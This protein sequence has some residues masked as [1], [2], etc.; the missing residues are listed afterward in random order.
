MGENRRGQR[1]AHA[2][3]V[4]FGTRF[5]DAV[6]YEIEALDAGDFALFLAADRFPCEAR[7]GAFESIGARLAVLCRERFSN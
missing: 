1:S 7:P 5:W 3:S 6:E 2:V 4:R